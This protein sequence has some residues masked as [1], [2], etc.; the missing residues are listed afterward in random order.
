[1]IIIINKTELYVQLTTYSF[2]PLIHIYQ[3]DNLTVIAITIMI[4]TSFILMAGENVILLR[5]NTN[6]NI[7]ERI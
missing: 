6:K 4:N 5:K 3:M 7:I 2:T 1:M